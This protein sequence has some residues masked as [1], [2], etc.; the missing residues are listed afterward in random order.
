MSLFLMLLLLPLQVPIVGLDR[1]LPLGLP[2]PVT[3]GAVYQQFSSVQQGSVQNIIEFSVP[4][5]LQQ[6]QG[7]TFT[8]EAR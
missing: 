3:V 4:F 6:Q 1:D 2:A 5:L 8:V 7:A